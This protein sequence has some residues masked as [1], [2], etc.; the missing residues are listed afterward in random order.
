M[1]QD[2]ELRTK[3]DQLK[4]GMSEKE[5]NEALGDFRKDLSPLGPY[6]EWTID[7]VNAYLFFRDGK[8]ARCD[9]GGPRTRVNVTVDSIRDPDS[10]V[11]AKLALRPGSKDVNMDDLQTKEY[12]VA[13]KRLLVDK[14]YK[15]VNDVEDSDQVVL[16]GFGISEPQTTTSDFV[17]PVYGMI[18][19]GVTTQSF[20]T[21]SVF[22]RH[23]SVFGYGSAVSHTGPQYGVVAVQKKTVSHTY[24]DRYL[25]LT[26][27]DTKSFKESEK[28]QMVWKSVV[29]SRGPS[30]DMR[31]IFPFLVVAMSDYVNVSSRK[32]VTWSLADNDPRLDEYMEQVDSRL[33]AAAR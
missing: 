24:F 19:S 6:T 15:I 7:R 17:A 21:A 2:A 20:G 30:D 29:S 32:K 18:S 12:L 13:V 3:V 33:P 28:E 23:G 1:S 25:V 10:P 4:T 14:G 26:A 31:D 5:V 16:I 9:F 27:Y 8:L 22:G 11:V